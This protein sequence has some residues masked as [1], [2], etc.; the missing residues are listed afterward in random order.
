MNSR[1]GSAVLKL[2]ALKRLDGVRDVHVRFSEKR[3]TVEYDPAKV[4]P[5]R[6]IHAINNLGYRANMAKGA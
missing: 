5:E 2:I 6:M 1:R 4:T 3:A